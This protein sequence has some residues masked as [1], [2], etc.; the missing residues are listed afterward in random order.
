MIIEESG[1]NGLNITNNHRR[2]ATLGRLVILA[3][4]GLTLWF[5]AMGAASAQTIAPSTP[6][7]PCPAPGLPSSVIPGWSGA[8]YCGNQFRVNYAIAGA[9]I[10]WTLGQV[11]LPPGGDSTFASAYGGP[12]PPITPVRGLVPGAKYA[13]AV[14]L[15]GNSA[16][17]TDNSGA[18]LAMPV[19]AFTVDID[20][21]STPTPPETGNTWVKH[22]YPFTAIGSTATLTLN[23]SP[24][25]CTG[26]FYVGADAVVQ[27]APDVSVVKAVSPTGTVQ[28]GSVV[29]Y[30]LTARNDGTDPTTNALLRDTPDAGLDC[31]TPSPTAIC[32]ATGG[33]SCPS[34]TVPVSTLTG[35]GLTIPNL[36]VNGQVVVTMQCKVTASGI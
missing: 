8:T 23:T 5:S 7:A 4:L 26:N 2:P 19:C 28:T 11:P 16:T 35:A 20:G 25:N 9:I 17:Y 18:S 14:Y 34:A 21:V 24:G 6:N 29:T 33:A 15:N 13:V 3:L 30:T 31:V 36:P 10:S 27:I 22:V 1:M 32:T 12:F